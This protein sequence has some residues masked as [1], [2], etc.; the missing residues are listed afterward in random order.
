ML[1]VVSW[2]FG[3]AKLYQKDNRKQLRTKMTHNIF[4]YFQYCVP[5]RGKNL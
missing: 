5:C 1:F 4:H 3:A 2:G